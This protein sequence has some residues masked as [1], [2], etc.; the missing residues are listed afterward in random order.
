MLLSACLIVKDEAWTIRKCL[1][2]LVDVVDEIIVV[3]TGCTDNTLAIVREYDAQIFNYEWNGDFSAARNESL[4]HA[5]GDFVLVIDADEFLDPMQRVNLRDFLAKTDADGVFIRLRNYTGSLTRPI[6]SPDVSLL[7][8]FRRG[9]NYSGYVH[10]QIYHSIKEMHGEVRELELTFHHMGYLDEFI[11]ARQK[12]SR[13]IELVMKELEDNPSEI[14][15]MTNLMAEYLR[16]GDFQ[17]CIQVGQKFFDLDDIQ[18]SSVPEPETHLYVRGVILLIMALV[19]SGEVYRAEQTAAEASRRYPQ[20][21]EVRKRHADTLLAL[22]RLTEAVDEFMECRELG[23]P[24]ITLFDTYP[25]LGSYLAAADLGVAWAMLGD[26]ERARHWFLTSFMENPS[27][28]HI[29]GSLLYLMPRDPHFLRENVES[30]IYD[31]LTYQTYVES[32]VILG[33]DGASGVTERYEKKFGNAVGG[34]SRMLMASRLG[35]NAME[36]VALDT[37][38]EQDLLLL[39]LY[40][41]NKNRKELALESLNEAG[42]RGRY[43]IDILERFETGTDS[44]LRIV[45]I[46]RELMALKA[47]QLLVKWLPRAEDRHQIWVDIKYSPVAHILGS[48]PWSGEDSWECEINASES[49][50]AKRLDTASQWLERALRFPPTVSKVLIECDL[51]L[52]HQNI[53]HATVTLSQ[54][55]E[56]FPESS[57]L[58]SVAVQLGLEGPSRGRNLAFR[59][60]YHLAGEDAMNPRDVYRQTSVQTMPLNIQLAQLH[61]R[62][63]LLTKLILELSRAQQINEMRKY[64]QELQD[65]L[66][67]LRSSL[68]MRLEVSK[69]TDSTYAFFYKVSVKWFLQP[70][71][72]EEDHDYMLSFWES[73]SDTWRRVRDL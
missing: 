58:S 17:K 27:V 63:G 66:T 34:A 48:M 56:Y 68:D 26:D 50:R 32:Y 60:L 18:G 13:N 70:N 33:L 24:K 39:G 21:V 8:I 29:I 72:V 3:D 67:F 37:K 2:S 47:E 52:A 38:N 51:A 35:R 54:G 5:S 16:G 42:D 45:P 40:D 55:Q 43:V 10:E 1:D 6:P 22:G 41:L 23:E 62:G 25:G 71:S 49:F 7:R 30:R 36:Q 31:W 9:H 44:R 15:H 53:E 11:S 14:F 73:W 69:T 65:I 20:V 12:V 46:V 4:K 57:I 64:I 19:L 61:E 28:P 59:T